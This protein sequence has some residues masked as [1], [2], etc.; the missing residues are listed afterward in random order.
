MRLVSV[1]C[2]CYTNSCD[3]DESNF[4]KMGKEG[5]GR[6]DQDLQRRVKCLLTSV[7]VLVAVL[8]AT[9]V[10]V[11]PAV[12]DADVAVFL[13]GERAFLMAVVAHGQAVIGTRGVLYVVTEHSFLAG[14]GLAD[15]APGLA[16]IV[17]TVG[18]AGVVNGAEGVGGPDQKDVV[19]RVDFIREGEGGYGRCHH[20]CHEGGED[21]GRHAYGLQ[22]GFHVF[23]LSI[24]F[25]RI[26]FV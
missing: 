20:Q 14:V 19:R 12:A 4:E 1:Q 6:S 15:D 3:F 13:D 8:D 24:G 23:P 5:K 9:V 25:P 16:A 2:A 7:A 11:L 10:R 22:L 17:D 26:L 21:G 18:I